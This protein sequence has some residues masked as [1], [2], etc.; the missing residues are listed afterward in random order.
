VQLFI[1]PANI[2]AARNYATKV[3]YTA[4]ILGGVKIPAICAAFIDGA[5]NPDVCNEGDLL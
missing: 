4:T 1:E 5:S 2:Y 3:K